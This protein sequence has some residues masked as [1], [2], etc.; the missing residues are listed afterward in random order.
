MAIVERR[1]TAEDY[2]KLPETNTPMQLIDG[3]LMMA[4]APIPIHQRIIRRTYD[5]INP[6]FNGGEV[7]F[8]P[9][10]VYLDDFNITQP[11]LLWISS[12]GNC[13]V[14]DKGLRGAPDWVLE[15]LSPG[16]AKQDRTKKYRLYEKYGVREYWIADALE[17]YIE[18][19]TLVDGAFKYIG[20]YGTGETFDSPLLGKTV[21]VT[22][23]FPPNETRI[24]E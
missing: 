2:F 13:I 4:P 22:A 14:T 5:V 20:A 6:L 21:D 11:D 16:T 24:P 19:W 15:V 18:V 12:D 3:E 7:F 23:I 17:E 8:S 10:D 1:M 9:T